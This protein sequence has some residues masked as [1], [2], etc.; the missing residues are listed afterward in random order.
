MFQLPLFDDG[1]R[2]RTAC[3]GEANAGMLPCQRIGSAGV[4]EGGKLDIVQINADLGR[5]A[6]KTE[7][8]GKIEAQRVTG[9]KLRVDL[10]CD[11]EQLRLGAIGGADFEPVLAATLSGS[12]C[13]PFACRILHLV[14]ATPDCKAILVAMRFIVTIDQCPAVK[15]RAGNQGKALVAVGCVFPACIEIFTGNDCAAQLQSR[16]LGNGSDVNA[17]SGKLASQL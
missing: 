13:M 5:V 7:V 4:V 2:L 14:A 6:T 9:A 17:Q 3:T 1:E 12:D 11:T 8:T 16:L 10:A 15:H